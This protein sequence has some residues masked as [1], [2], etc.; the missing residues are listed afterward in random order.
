MKQI[1]YHEIGSSGPHCCKVNKQLLVYQNTA[2]ININIGNSH[3]NAVNAAGLTM[4]KDDIPLK[5]SNSL[6][7]NLAYSEE[8]HRLF[9]SEVR[10]TSTGLHAKTAYGVHAKCLHIVSEDSSIYSSRFEQRWSLSFLVLESNHAHRR[11]VITS[12][13]TII[14]GGQPLVLSTDSKSGLEV[15]SAFIVVR[16]FFHAHPYIYIYLSQQ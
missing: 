9:R 10:F 11:H 8:E 13:I 6:F 14:M 1:I 5:N 15:V 16:C 2:G 4:R 3:R 12:L 7:S